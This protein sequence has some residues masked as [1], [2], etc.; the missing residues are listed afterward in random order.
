MHASFR[1]SFT[2]HSQLVNPRNGTLFPNG[3]YREG[4]RLP[5]EHAARVESLMK[6]HL[7]QVNKL[8]TEH[9]ER[10]EEIATEYRKS[11]DGNAE[12]TRQ[13]TAGIQRW[14]NAPPRRTR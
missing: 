5:G 3:P 14:M 7:A 10:L 1:D 4:K 9:A 8:H 13:L 12:A 6:E 2:G 11:N